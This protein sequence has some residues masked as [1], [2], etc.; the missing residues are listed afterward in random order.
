MNRE[1]T[2]NNYTKTRS[3]P[4][5]SIN[6]EYMYKETTLCSA[7]GNGAQESGVRSQLNIEELTEEKLPFTNKE[8]NGRGAAQ[9]QSMFLNGYRGGNFRTTILHIL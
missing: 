4:L 8:A 9:D 7:R 6:A 2:I 5:Q 1:E 3:S